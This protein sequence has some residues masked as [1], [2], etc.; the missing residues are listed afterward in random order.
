MLKRFR[1]AAVAGC[2]L[3]AT[4]LVAHAA[5]YFPGFP[6]VGGA[7]YCQGTSTGT[8]GQV[9]TVTVPAGPSVKTGLELVPA[10]TQ[11]SQGQAPQT[12]YLSLA[13]LNALPTQYADLAATT[14]TNT[15]NVNATTGKLVITSSA[16]LSP[17]TVVLPTAPIDGQ[18]LDIS[19]N[20]TIAT[21]TL[22]PTS[23]NS[24]TA[25]TTST[26]GSYGY[27]L[28]WRA[29]TAKWYRLQ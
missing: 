12:V 5:G 26:T 9:C 7:S 25:L 29:S 20:A 21:L 1:S 15:V 16:A 11:A 8:S 6:I 27:K 19:S 3:I 17:T 14:A 23:Q 10:D 22:S 18:T 28:V 2:A 4:V 13:S 24:P